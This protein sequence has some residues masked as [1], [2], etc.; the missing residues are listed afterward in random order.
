MKI[1]ITNFENE[2]IEMNVEFSNFRSGHG[3]HSVICEVEYNGQ[4][5]SIK[6]KTSDMPFIDS[7]DEMT[8]QE[9][10]LAFLEKF[11]LEENLIEFYYDVK[12]A[13]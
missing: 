10:Q 5:Y 1:E 8:Y 4:K 3:H 7:L 2:Q 11:D 6:T 13:E 12:D 9:K